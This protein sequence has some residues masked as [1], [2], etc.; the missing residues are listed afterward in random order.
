MKQRLLYTALMLFAVLG[1]A[2][3]ADVT[4]K[5]TSNGGMPVT[6]T[7]DQA[8]SVTDLTTTHSG[9][10]TLSNDKKKIT[11]VQGYLTEVEITSTSATTATVTG[12][13]NKLDVAGEDK[14]KTLTLSK[15]NYVKELI[16][17]GSVLQSLTCSG[18]GMETL[19]LSGASALKTLDASNNKLE[20]SKL[21]LPTTLEKLDLSDNLLSG[22]S[23]DVSTYTALKELN[24][25]KNQLTDVL[26]LSSLN[27]LAK[28]NL[29]DNWIKALTTKPGK[30]DCA[31]TWGV[32][33][34]TITSPNNATSANEGFRIS[35]LIEDAGIGDKSQ[36]FSNVS[37]QIED[38]N[39]YIE[40]KNQTAHQQSGAWADEYRFYNATTKEF[41]NGTYQCSLKTGGRDYKIT[42]LAVKL[43]T[44][45]LKGEEPTNA[46][47]F[48]V[49]VNG[50]AAVNVASSP[51]VKQG[52]KLNFTLTPEDGYE[53][54]VYTIE[55]MVPAVIGQQ[56]PY[57]GTSFA[58]VVKGLYKSQSEDV[59]PKI[60][61]VVLGKEHTVAY[62][63]K[64]QV[65][66]SFTVQKVSGK[67][68]SDVASG[69]AISTGDKLLIKIKP[70]TGYDFILAINGVDK[71][72]DVTQTGA[73]TDFT[74]SEDITDISYKDEKTI[75]VSVT[76][77]NPTINAYVKV[78]GQIL[79]STL[80]YI[81]DNKVTLIDH[82]KKTQ[83][84]TDGK[85]KSLV[86]NTTYQALFTVGKS[87]ATDLVHRLKD[88]TINGGELISVNKDAATGNNMNYTVAFKVEAS[89]VVIS[90][91][92]KKMQTVSITPVVNDGS[93]GQKQI[94]DGK[95]KPVLFST[96]PA[97]LNEHVKITYKT[98]ATPA[99]DMGT[100]APVNAGT[101]KATFT[102]EETDYYIPDATN[103]TKTDF[104]LEVSKAPLTIKTLPTVTIDK[105]GMYVISGG[106]VTFNNEKVNGKF[107]ITPALSPTPGESHAVTVNFEP[108]SAVDKANYEDATA[109]VNVIVRDSPLNL[110]KV[111]MV[112]LPSSYSIQWLNGNK[113]V[114]IA[115]EGFAANT[116]LTAV[117]TYP[118]GT[119]D[120]L[121][122]TTSTNAQSTIALNAAASADGTL[123][124]DVTMKENTEFRVVAGTGNKYSVKFKDQA[125]DYT[126]E[127][128]SYNPEKGLTI[129]DKDDHSVAWA[130]ISN[131]VSVTYKDASGKVVAKPVDAGT[132][133]VCVSIKENSTTGYVETVAEQAAFVVNK[134]K[135]LVYKWP[136]ASVIAKG[137]SLA[138]SDL[139][140]GAANIPGTF[141]WKNTAESFPTPGE[142][143]RSVLFVPGDAYEK[144]YLTV[145]TRGGESLED[146][147]VEQNQW[148]KFAVSELQ[149][150]TFVQI[151]GTITVTNQLGQTLPTGSAVMK[152]D[153]LTIKVEPRDG[154]ELKSLT[155]NGANNT[156]VYTVGTSSVAIEATFQPKAA[157]P[158]PSDPIIDPNS[159][160]AVTLPKANDVRGVMIG[161]PG[162]NAVLKDKPFSFTLNT[163]AADAE[164]VVVKVNGSELKPVDGTY[165]IAKVSENT[166]VQ[167][168]L[169]SPTPLNVVVETVAKNANGYMMGKVLVEGPSDGVCYYNDK[170]MLAA[171]PESGVTFTGWSDDKD[172]K[173]PVR[174]LTLTKDVTIKALFSGIPT[175]IESIQT[176][177]VYGVEGYLVIEGVAKGKVT[178]VGMDGRVQYHQ[179]SGDI[180]IPLAT[181]VYGYVLEDGSKVIRNK[182]YVK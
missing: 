119:K 45:D 116:K 36:A 104:D 65:G 112:A 83:E 131:D 61:A 145:E 103:G 73:G 37:W 69:D 102:F 19:T 4:I 44:F 82:D 140:E 72:G 172:V 144:N 155:V 115:T 124:Y 25:S 80:D 149:I 51:K 34:L 161:K 176:A 71:T 74:Y 67:T 170:I 130:A 90:I 91:T 40:D 98:A 105:A 178:V 84:I 30:A 81:K 151:E 32:Q 85:E 17:S 117:V 93:T 163:L 94:Y 174:T 179:I 66:G 169:A 171:D 8:A 6:V 26:G 109:S 173:N 134:I 16:V 21:S 120:V 97:N 9:K 86:T 77:K 121:L 177:K 75:T 92:T 142:Y 141:V 14:L 57:K 113:P 164:K 11:L 70:N 18:L 43:A 156:G 110:Y 28:L 147:G 101:Y 181:G 162:V 95:A 148:V 139:T 47:T 52:D 38:G 23:W 107:S 46:K 79:S 78:D 22:G 125:V 160:Y 180:R 29:S 13:M 60:S 111:T 153:V 168:S 123:V 55:G 150:V 3:A 10:V 53:T 106:E 100:V 137:Q 99:L 56:A 96:E 126:G 50:A 157:D 167:V 41:V 58:C 143:R 154:L 114:N 127:P 5:V 88:I 2:R 12:R 20:T 138:Q 76:F 59:S 128:L 49:S 146:T 108:A 133:T 182:V 175:G 165:T 89:D 63:K 136:K 27:N 129:S 54:A 152:G 87:A 62:E 159:Q 118:K 42:N 24:V 122:E 35:K 158:E 68:T 7:L 15:D 64:T 166:T 48:Q 31:I 132:Y 39:V 1:M 33:T 135:P